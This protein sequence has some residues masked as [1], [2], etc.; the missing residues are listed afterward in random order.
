MTS[1]FVEIVPRPIS[2][3]TLFPLQPSDDM[4]LVIGQRV[5]GHLVV[6]L[7]IQT[8]DSGL[9]IVSWG[10]WVFKSIFY[11]SGLDD[12]DEFF[13]THAICLA[14]QSKYKLS[15][16]KSDTRNGYGKRVR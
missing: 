3:V 6:S 2:K 4:I 7:A 15:Q 13:T 9:R 16:L 11:G 14:L 12:A 8:L 5:E 10:F 1:K